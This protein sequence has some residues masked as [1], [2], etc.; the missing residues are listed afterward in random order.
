MARISRKNNFDIEVIENEKDK[1]YKTAFYI[2]LSKEDKNN[3]SIQNQKVLLQNYIK[4]K[5]DFE[6]IDIFIDNGYSGGTLD[7]PQFNKLMDKVYKKEID[8]II[9][10]DLS[11]L[12]RN[13]IAVGDFLE[14]TIKD[15]NVRLIAVNDN[16][17]SINEFDT[18]EIIIVAFKN[19]INEHYLKD[20]SEKIKSYFRVKREKQEVF[21]GVAPYGYVK[22][23]DRKKYVI[24]NKSAEIVKEIFR[25]RADEKLGYSKIAKILTE[26]NIDTPTTYA[27]KENLTTRKKGSHLWSYTTV[28]NILNNEVYIGT[29]VTQIKKTKIKNVHEPII[30]IDTF[31]KVKNYN[32]EIKTSYKKSVNKKSSFNNILKGKL[33]CAC[34][35]NM[36]VTYKK[37]YYISKAT[38]KK[39]Y[40]NHVK[41][42]CNKKNMYGDNY[43]NTKS[44]LE[45][46]LISELV[47]SF[48]KEKEILKNN[49]NKIEL[50]LKEERFRNLLLTFEEQL[51]QSENNLSKSQNILNNLYSDYKQSI[52]NGEEYKKI[53]EHYVTVKEKEIMKA[54]ELKEKISFLNGTFIENNEWVQILNTLVL[55]NLKINDYLATIIKN[56]EFSKSDIA[57]K[58]EHK[59]EF[60]KIIKF[61]D[62]D[63]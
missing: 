49:I 13:Y 33:T 25:L 43:C 60:N 47:K 12:G 55:E 6:I 16:F 50:Q 28:K 21:G 1:I 11:R 9:T 4:N 7:R 39:I 15:E 35:E 18:S 38:G 3:N 20:T 58:F 24:D 5:Y 63:F 27:I 42:Y 26:K 22:S 30:D 53:K 57:V 37:H 48:E 41:Y 59:N 31:N 34:G 10:K 61:F 36:R 32:N 2:R 56:I 51:K 14:N 40:N 45:N 54:N 52:I 29:L 46:V 19:I 44:Y 62:N 17:D 8:C 23:E